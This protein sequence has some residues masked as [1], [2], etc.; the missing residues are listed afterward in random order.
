MRRLCQSSVAVLIAP[1]LFEGVTPAA[2][3]APAKVNAVQSLP[4][5]A[6]AWLDGYRLRWPLR[7]IGD[8]AKHAARSVITSLP[9]GGW[10]KPDASDVAVQAASGE[11]L[12]VTVLSHD[13]AG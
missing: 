7:I 9:T 8:P 3:P 12:P 4:D 10:L 1:I 5:K 13:P 6:P 11:V 2:R